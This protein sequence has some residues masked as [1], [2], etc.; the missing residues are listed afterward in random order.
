MESR[1]N[2]SRRIYKE[3]GNF[4]IG[5]DVRCCSERRSMTISVL[6]KFSV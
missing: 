4:R 5:G 6:G 1:E 2:W 3:G